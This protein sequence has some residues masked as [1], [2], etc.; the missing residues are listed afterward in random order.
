[1]KPEREAGEKPWRLLQRDARSRS[2]AKSSRH[3]NNI[4]PETKKQRHTTS[5]CP[6]RS[7]AQLKVAFPAEERSHDLIGPVISAEKE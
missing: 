5:V 6:R 2:P 4:T 1:M 3:E 7:F